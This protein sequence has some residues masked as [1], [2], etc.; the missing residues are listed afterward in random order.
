MIERLP[1]ETDGPADARSPGRARSMGT[2]L[3]DFV[4]PRLAIRILLT[5]AA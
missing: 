1:G 3:D 2:A 5:F 4:L